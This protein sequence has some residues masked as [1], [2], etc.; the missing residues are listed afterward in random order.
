MLKFWKRKKQEM[1]IQLRDGKL[2]IVVRK[3]SVN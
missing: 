3:R 1:D 2:V